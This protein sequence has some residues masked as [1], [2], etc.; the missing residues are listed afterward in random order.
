MVLDTK[1]GAGSAATEAAKLHLSRLWAC[2][3]IGV[4]TGALATSAEATPVSIN[5]SSFSGINGGLAAGGLTIIDPF[6]TTGGGG[7][8]LTNNV[9]GAA[10][11]PVFMSG[12]FIAAKFTTAATP[13]NFAAGTLIDAAAGGG[14]FTNNGTNGNSLFRLGATASPD[15]GPNSFLG[16]K[17]ALGRYGY[18]ETTWNSTSNQFQIFSAAYESV[19]G[20]GIMTPSGAAVPEIDPSGLASTMSLVMGSVAML[21]QRR[22][23]RAAVAAE[24]AAVTA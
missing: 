20:V 2:L 1:C 13:V 12:G 10:T 15:F 22:R 7:L 4:V 11:G 16:F 21:E 14:G 8:F 23:K 9:G 6:P 17:D 19:A 3:A 24:S 5:V 18:I